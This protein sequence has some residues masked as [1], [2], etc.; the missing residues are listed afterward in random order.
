MA[1]NWLY[2]SFRLFV[3]STD[4]DTSVYAI[5]M[6]SDSLRWRR[7][8]QVLQVCTLNTNGLFYSTVLCDESLG[9][10]GT[11]VRCYISQVSS[12]INSPVRRT[13]SFLKVQCE[14]QWKEQS[15]M[16]TIVF[17]SF[18]VSVMLSL[19]TALSLNSWW[20]GTGA[21]LI[22]LTHGACINYFF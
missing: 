14:E 3:C 5:Y 10:T 6:N 1:V 15:T 20:G 8:K 2:K 18:P 16:Q 22:R 7:W 11:E 9:V 17:V 4:R 19:A 21:A 12:L 13:A